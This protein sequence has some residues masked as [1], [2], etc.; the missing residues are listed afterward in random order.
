MSTNLSTSMSAT[1]ILADF[2]QPP[3]RPPCPLP[4]R[5][6]CVPPCQPP[7]QPPQCRLGALWGLR[8]VSKKITFFYKKSYFF[9]KKNYFFLQKKVT[10]FY[11]KKLLFFAKKSTSRTLLCNTGVIRGDTPHQWTYY[12]D[13]PEQ[14]ITC[15]G[16]CTHCRV[17]LSI[18]IHT[19]VFCIF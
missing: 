9:Y 7:C 8:D 1:S 6:P 5:P 18:L 19:N 15:G 16:V 11:K 14:H 13:D 12:M 17:Q 2:F 10:F 3:C 4:C